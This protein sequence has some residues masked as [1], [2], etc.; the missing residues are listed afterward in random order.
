MRDSFQG[1]KVNIVLVGAGVDFVL[2]SKM[3]SVQIRTIK[4][5]RKQEKLGKRTE[6]EEIEANGID[7][8]R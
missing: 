6:R 2:D 3:D 1:G 7:L 8:H 4:E 5:T